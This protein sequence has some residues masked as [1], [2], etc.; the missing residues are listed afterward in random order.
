MTRAP[1]I[2]GVL[3]GFCIAFCVLIVASMFGCH[4]QSSA[5]VDPIAGA[6]TV[7]A[8]NASATGRGFFEDD[9]MQHGW[10]K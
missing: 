5:P 8:G 9:A 4:A 6:E 1:S 3:T 10:G 2:A 7:P